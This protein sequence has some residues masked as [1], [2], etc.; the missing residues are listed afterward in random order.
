MKLTLVE[1]LRCPECRGAMKLAPGATPSAA[2]N[3]VDEGSLACLS[4]ARAYPIA[5]GIPRFVGHG[6]YAESFGYQWTK[7]SRTQLDEHLGVPLSA[8]R[9]EKETGW[10]RSLAGERVLEAGSG[11]GRFTRCAAATG[12]EILSF[13]YSEAIDANYRNNRHLPNVHFLQADIYKPPFAPGT[14]DRIFCFGVLQHTPDPQRSFKSL[15]PLLRPG[16]ELVSDVYRRSWKTL[17]WGQYYL[18]VITR[19]LPP[20]K[21]FPIVERYFNVVHAAT[22]LLLPISSHFSKMVSLLLGT[23]DYRGLYPIRPDVMKE[24]C[25]LDTF[26]KLSPAFDHPQTLARVRRWFHDLEVSSFD[27]KPGY[28]GIEI[29]VRR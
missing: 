22:G 3:E 15:L 29:H 1:L 25:L 5:G 20:D 4:C 9:F 10:P 13:D 2:P 11:M 8:E 14:F 23:A 26:D 16:G 21:L 12:A 27:V 7:F 18:R 28:N 24:W 6:N 19:R 17:F